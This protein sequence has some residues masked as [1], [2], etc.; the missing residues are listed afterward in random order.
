MVHSCPHLVDPSLVGA[1]GTWANNHVKEAI[2]QFFSPSKVEFP[3]EA[4]PGH[5]AGCDVL[6]AFVGDHIN[7]RAHY[8]L[9]IGSWKEQI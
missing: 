2:A 6:E 9:P 8:C 5:I 4:S 1:P 7:H 3:V